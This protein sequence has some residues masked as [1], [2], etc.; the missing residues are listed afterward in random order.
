MFLSLKLL[1][2]SRLLKPVSFFLLLVPLVLYFCPPLTLSGKF[3]LSLFY[4]LSLLSPLSSHL[5]LY[6]LA[7]LHLAVF[8]LFRLSLFCS[9]LFLSH[10]LFLLILLLP[11]AF[12]LL[13]LLCSNLCFPCFILLSL[14]SNI[15]FH[16]LLHFPVVTKIL[17]SAP[18]L[19]LF[20][21]PSVLVLSDILFCFIV[22]LWR[23]SFDYILGLLCHFAGFLLLERL[24]Y[25]LLDKLNFL[26]FSLIVQFL[27]VLILLL[28]HRCISLF[29]FLLPLLR[30][31]SL[32]V[33]HFCRFNFRKPSLWWAV[34]DILLWSLVVYHRFHRASLPSNLLKR[35]ITLLIALLLLNLDLKVKVSLCL[36]L[37]V[38]LSV[39]LNWPH[40]LVWRFCVSVGSSLHNFF[41]IVLPRNIH[42]GR[43][44][45]FVFL[46]SWIWGNLSDFYAFL[47]LGRQLQVVV[48]DSHRALVQRAGNSRELPQILLLQKFLL[49]HLVVGD[50]KDFVTEYRVSYFSL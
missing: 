25:V 5:T 49:N 30:L 46:S 40:E 7:L 12:L 24:V 16:H 17:I 41:I 27:V 36:E 1:P 10:L 35:T 18:L 31:L 45:G 42:V 44:G 13:T 23:F 34:L 39:F 3:L 14:F 20:Q 15:L 4:L 33:F 8:H 22:S 19:R 9:L 50:L 43:M 29:L 32:R 28:P 48:V 26:L 2:L 37:F 21:S 38:L 6:S 11:Q 47:Q